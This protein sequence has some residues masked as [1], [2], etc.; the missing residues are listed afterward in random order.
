MKL[1]LP[2]DLVPPSLAGSILVD[3]WGMPRYWGHAWLALEGNEIS[4]STRK[5]MQSAIERLHSAFEKR[6]GDDCLDRVLSQLDLKT[7]VAVLQGLFLELRNDG[8]DADINTNQTWHYCSRFVLR[9]VQLISLTRPNGT[10]TKRLLGWIRRIDAHF[11]SIKPKSPQKPMKVR[12]IPADVVEEIFEIIDPKSPKNPFRTAEIAFR[13]Y[14][15]VIIFFH[16]GLRRGELCLLVLD[17]VRQEIDRRTGRERFWLNVQELPDD[18][19]DPRTERPSIK[20]VHSVR[21]VPIARDLAKLIETYSTGFRKAP[22]HTVLFS[23]QKGRPLSLGMVD[24]VFRAVSDRLSVKAKKLLRDRGFNSKVTPHEARHTAAVV[25][26]TDLI[27]AGVSLPEALD[28]LKVFFG[29]S[30]ESEMPRHYARGYFEERLH[31]VWER[32]WDTHV[33][34]L[35]A[36]A[37]E[38]VV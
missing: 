25:R 1:S 21:Q 29:W 5:K 6:L 15:I 8:L 3:D 27:D 32:R 2:R 33:D 13:N 4:E 30:K 36:L 18:V 11:R 7:I 38:P 22:R 35:R 12:A 17:A 23:S 10:D 9:T 14:V 26:L 16:L 37:S 31:M 28:M 19:P 34:R 24:L 20:T